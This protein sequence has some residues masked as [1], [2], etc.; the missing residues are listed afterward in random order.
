MTEVKIYTPGESFVCDLHH[1][2]NGV[3]VKVLADET[4]NTKVPPAAPM[5]EDEEKIFFYHIDGMYSLCR[6]E[7]GQTCHLVAW[8]KVEV[9]SE[10]PDEPRR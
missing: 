1:A 6:K 9:L 4:V 7:N 8:Q 5:I 2:P 3:W 10:Q